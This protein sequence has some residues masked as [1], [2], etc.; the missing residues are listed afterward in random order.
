VGHEL[1][2]GVAS[3][4]VVALGDVRGEPAG[5]VLRSPVWTLGPQALGRLSLRFVAPRDDGSVDRDAATRPI[6]TPAAVHHGPG[7]QPPAGPPHEAHAIGLAGLEHPGPELLPRPAQLDDP[8]GNVVSVEEVD[9]LGRPD[10]DQVGDEP[11]VGHLHALGPPGVSGIDVSSARRPGSVVAIASGGDRSERHRED[12]H[13]PA[14]Q[15]VP[16]LPGAPL[17]PPEGCQ[18]S[19]SGR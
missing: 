18:R 3:A 4:E 2:R 11:A 17:I 19:D 14:S 5:A 9:R 15:D 10:G 12:V 16:P 6:L 13:E 7:A 1:L 8:V